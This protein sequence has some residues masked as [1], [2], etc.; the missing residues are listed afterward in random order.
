MNSAS[1]TLPGATAR[2]GDPKETAIS[3]PMLLARLP[4]YWS[5]YRPNR[6]T[7]RPEE[8]GHGSLLWSVRK[9]TLV[10]RSDGASVV[11]TGGASLFVRP[12]LTRA[13]SASARMAR[14]FFERISSRMAVR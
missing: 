7:T 8:T 9:F 12:L 3:I 10:T 6:R 2:T 1:L 14:S 11:R 13:C 5:V 4:V